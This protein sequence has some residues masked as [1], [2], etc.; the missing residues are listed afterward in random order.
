[1]EDK[2]VEP[3]FVAALSKTASSLV[4]RKI[5]GLLSGQ[6]KRPIK[7]AKEKFLSAWGTP[8]PELAAVLQEVIAKA[9]VAT[10]A[11][12]VNGHLDEQNT[13]TFRTPVDI[14]N[15]EKLRNALKALQQKKSYEIA[16]SI[17]TIDILPVK[18][19]DEDG[20]LLATLTTLVGQ[21]FGDLPQDLQRKLQSRLVPT[22]TE[23]LWYQI[24]RSLEDKE[25][26]R[27][28]YA[29][30]FQGLS[31]IGESVENAESY[32][33][34]AVD[35]IVE[36]SSQVADIKEGGEHARQERIERIE[37]GKEQYRQWLIQ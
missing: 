9:Y 4:I 33:R 32:A 13:K 2:S 17:E 14:E 1:M 22:L 10:I 26:Q 21:T 8:P 24:T 28:V 35:Q 7:A 18:N 3:I 23:K 37:K 12:L 31:R 25:G 29:F 36:L 34:K 5:I 19:A 15:D 11:D 30:I 6:A 16:P 20:E 27:I